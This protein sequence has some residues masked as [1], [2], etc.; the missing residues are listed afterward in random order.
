MT[1]FETRY[2]FATA[3]ACEAAISEQGLTNHFAAG[4]LRDGVERFKIMQYSA[5][6]A[7]SDA[8]VAKHAGDAESSRTP[9]Q[10]GATGICKQLAA[11][12]PETLA[13]KEAFVAACAELGVVAGTASTQWYRLRAK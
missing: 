11:E 6:D 5:R 10:M 8:P 9:R 3:A 2:P 12:R 7:R 13:T 4:G 1:D